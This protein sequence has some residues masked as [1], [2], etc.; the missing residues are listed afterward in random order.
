MTE[1][2]LKGELHTSN[3][4]LDEERE[5]LKAGV[6]SL[7]LEGDSPG[8]DSE[9]GWLDGWFSISTWLFDLVM[10]N[11]YVSKDILVD[12]A[13]A[14]DADVVYTR[15]SNSELIDNTNRGLKAVSAV[16][17]YLLVAAG[18]VWGYNTG[19]LISGAALLFMGVLVPILLLRMYNTK[20]AEGDLN[21][22]Q[23]I[24]D[25]IVDASENSSRVVAV[26]GEEHVEGIERRLPSDL[27]VDTKG[28]AYGKLSKPHLKELMLP[29]FTAFSV[30]FVFY[31]LLLEV[32]RILLPI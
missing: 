17:F 28:L 22:D 21:R 2:V 5:L 12:L 31:V 24:A 25:K 15:N 18:L 7:V 4:D 29:G 30:L 32:S 8:K 10:R 26:V 16:L 1:V 19:D 3:G 11:V 6:D 20:L 9:P 27:Q 14:Q 23:I 13:E